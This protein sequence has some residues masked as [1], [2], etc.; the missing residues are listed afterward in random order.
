MTINEHE[1]FI[2]LYNKLLVKEQS[3]DGMIELLQEAK[4]LGLDIVSIENALI[5]AR[6]S[7]RYF[8]NKVYFSYLKGKAKLSSQL[9]KMPYRERVY[10][11]II[12]RDCIPKSFHPLVERLY[13]TENQFSL[14]QLIFLNRSTDTQIKNLFADDLY[15]KRIK[16]RLN[17]RTGN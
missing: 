12:N 13:K 5:R 4:D 16:K 2:K 10:V 9:L 1:S 14:E 11:Q 6:K 15:T 8:K 17:E 3:L 7:F